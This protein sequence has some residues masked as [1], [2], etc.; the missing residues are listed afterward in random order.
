MAKLVCGGWKILLACIIPPLYLNIRRFYVQFELQKCFIL[1]YK[2]GSTVAFCM[3]FFFFLS[4]FVCVIGL[5]GLVKGPVWGSGLVSRVVLL[6]ERNCDSKKKGTKLFAGSKPPENDRWL[7]LIA[8]CH[9]CLAASASFAT[10]PSSKPRFI[11]PN[12]RSLGFGFD[13]A[14]RRVPRSD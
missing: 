5:R 6:G 4:V 2:K 10:S 11:L 13:G 7:F 3:F 1:V 14:R 12:L 8:V 9:L